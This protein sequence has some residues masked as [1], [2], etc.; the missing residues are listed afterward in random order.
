M[1]YVEWEK[2]RGPG[3][4]ESSLQGRLKLSQNRKK[5]SYSEKLQKERKHNDLEFCL[6]SMIKK[7][8]YDAIVT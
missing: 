1:T 2:G 4:E 8:Y 6:H 5:T 7:H 3:D